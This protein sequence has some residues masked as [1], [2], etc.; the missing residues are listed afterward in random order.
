MC[1]TGFPQLFI[2]PALIVGD[3]FPE[4]FIVTLFLSECVHV[5]DARVMCTKRI[6]MV[7]CIM[8]KN[9]HK[10]V[11][12]S[13]LFFKVILFWVTNLALLEIV[14]DFFVRFCSYQVFRSGVFTVFQNVAVI[15]DKPYMHQ[16]FIIFIL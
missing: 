12:Y 9:L 1:W 14:T 11:I 8:Y 4:I 15:C 2:N 16:R 7:Q 10:K 3:L 6:Q 5:H 13:Y